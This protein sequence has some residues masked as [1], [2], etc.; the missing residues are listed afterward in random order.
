MSY[1]PY[2]SSGDQVTPQN[3]G[4]PAPQSVLNAVKLMYVGAGLSVLGLI[5]LAVTAGGLR[6]RIENDHPTVNGKPAT[7][8]QIT[9]LVHF[10]IALGIIGGVIGVALWLWM[11]KKT[12]QG[13][14]WARI[15]SSVLFALCTLD[16]LNVFRGTGTSAFTIISAVLTWLVGLGAIVLLWVPSSSPY[17]VSQRRQ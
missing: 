3:P 9:A 4:G 12:G 6:Q 10:S 14:P 11:A 7:A 16:L 13:R 17:F 1:Q 8:T 2:P 5:A 15:L